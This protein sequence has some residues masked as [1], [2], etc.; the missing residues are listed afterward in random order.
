MKIRMKIRQF[1]ALFSSFLIAA[2]LYAV[3]LIPTT[4]LGATITGGKDSILAIAAMIIPV[5]VV[6]VAIGWI[7]SAITTGRRA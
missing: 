1:F 5:V 2:P 3:E 4:E 7:I 6:L